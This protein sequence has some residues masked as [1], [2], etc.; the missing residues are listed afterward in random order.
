MDAGSFQ[1][2]RWTLVRAAGDSGISSTHALNALSELC[3]IYWPP[4]YGYLRR[5]GYDRSDAQDLTQSFFQHV[6]ENE[7]LRRASREKGRFR[8]FLLGALKLCLADERA[9]RHALK[10]GGA[11]HFIS[12]DELEAE[13]LH[14]QRLASDLSPDESLDARWA[15]LLLDR[16]IGAL[17]DE[18][19]DKAMLETFEALLPFLGGEKADVSYEEV[20]RRLA[21]SLPAVKTL[22]HR[23]RQQFATAVRREIMQTVC[24]PHEVD[25]EL[26]QL[27]MVFARGAERQ[28]A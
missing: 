11:M 1:S 7:T 12:M 14:H 22:I 28:S 2:T 19:A 16:A 10:R 3:R 23:L 8:N 17:H 6:L 18:F 26:R 5:K 13:E 9:R 21:I 20:A 25:D 27:R 4:I 15:G 24:A